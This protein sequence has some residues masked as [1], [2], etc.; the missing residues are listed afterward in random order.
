MKQSIIQPHGYKCF[1][2]G[3]NGN[4]DKLERHHIFGGAN[5]KKSDEDGLTVWLCGDRC[6]RNGRYAAHQNRNTMDELHRAGESIWIETFGTK[7]EFIKRYGK[8]YL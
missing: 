8:D 1:L 6:H 2:C 5:R 3:R 7:E 4:G